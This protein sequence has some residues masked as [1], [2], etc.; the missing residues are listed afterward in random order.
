VF[1]GAMIGLLGVGG[2]VAAITAA[3]W[4]K[5]NSFDFGRTG[6]AAFYGVITGAIGGVIGALIGTHSTESWEGV[7]L[8]KR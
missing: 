2:G 8:P 1:K 7:T 3:T 4:K 5:T 6:D